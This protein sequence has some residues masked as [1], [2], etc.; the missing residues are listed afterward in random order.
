MNYMENYELWLEKLGGK[1]SDAVSEMRAMSETEREE[2]FSMPMAFGTGGLRAVRGMGPGRMNKYTIARVTE[3]LAKVVLAS[4]HEKTVV[5][6]YDT[7]HGST[8]FAQ[9]AAGVL[10][11]NGITVYLFDQPAPTPA[12]SF[13]VRDLKAGFGIVITASHNPKKYNGYKVYNSRGVQ[14]LPE[15]AAPVMDEIEKVSMFS[16]KGVSLLEAQ[17]NGMLRYLGDEQLERYAKQ[18][19]ELLPRSRQLRD[20]MKDF[21]IVYT[22]LYGSGAVPVTKVIGMQGFEKAAFIQQ[23]PDGDFGGLYMP[24]PEAPEVYAEAIREAEKIGAKILMATDPDSD[25]VGA[26]VMHDGGFVPLSGNQMGALLLNYLLEARRQHKDLRDTDLV[27]TTIV[28]GDMGETIAKAYGLSPMRVLTGFKYIGALAEKEAYQGR[29][30]VFGYEESYGY[31]T[32]NAVRDKDA[33]IAVTL[34]LEMAVYYAEKGKDLFEVFLDLSRKHGGFAESLKTITLSGLDFGKKIDAIM[35]RLRS[36]EFDGIGE[37]KAAD[38]ADYEKGYI[39]RRDGSK[40]KLD[41]P[42]SDVLKIFFEDGSWMAARPSGTEPKM[43]FYLSAHGK[44]YHAAQ[45][46][47]ARLGEAIDEFLK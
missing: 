12:L 45:E 27:V 42:K 30:F 37:F 15:E 36:P 39:V 1:D 10:C 23:N 3:G 2:A 13:S 16:A 20:K 35:S 24:N 34:I 33:V 32:G 41:L 21:P 47:L 7:R 46:T 18:V 31:L 22:A 40:E 14:L 26:M 19:Y 6:A 5:I 4:P 8:E 9:V 29:R 43:K 38:I 44:T 25:R 11:E 17:E 28:S